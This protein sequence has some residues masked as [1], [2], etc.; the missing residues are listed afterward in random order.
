VE[1][2]LKFW[3]SA[4]R[5]AE[6]LTQCEPWAPIEQVIIYNAERV[7]EHEIQFIASEGQRLLSEIPGVRDVFAGQTIQQDAKYQLCWI[8][9][10]AHKTVMQHYREHPNHIT[11]NERLFR[12][13][14]GTRISIDYEDS[15]AK[16]PDINPRMPP[17]R[18]S[19]QS[20]GM[21]LK[22]LLAH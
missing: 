1:R 3:G 9:R 17:N 13:Y 10:F 2:C 12:P 20:V 11:F 18:L 5:A 6:V 8:I 21:R 16:T 4:G 14:V 15:T 19:N 7:S 22:P